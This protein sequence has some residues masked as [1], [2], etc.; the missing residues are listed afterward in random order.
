[1]AAK[2][3][4]TP[5]GPYGWTGT[6]AEQSDADFLASLDADDAGALYLVTDQP[7]RV[8][9]YDGVAWVQT[10]YGG[11]TAFVE[12]NLIYLQDNT[13]TAGF[14]YFGSAPSGTAEVSALWTMSRMT[15]ST[16]NTYPV[17]GG[18]LATWSNRA[19]ETYA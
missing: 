8:D 14:T 6:L 10:H 12:P 18:G 16:G 17:S 3:F 2:R 9:E 15:N 11:A 4:G 1:M 5:P 13:T 7:G 19:S